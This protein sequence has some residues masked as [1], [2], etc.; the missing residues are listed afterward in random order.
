MAD[1]TTQIGPV[2]LLGPPGAG[3]GTQARNIV[4][5]YGI[6]QISTGDLLR[7]H[8]ARGTALGLE[9]KA[10]MAR[11]ELVPDKLMYGIV[12]DR[13]RAPDCR[14]GFV[15]DGFPRTA[16]QAGWLNAFLGKEL[17]D[18]SGPCAPLVLQL[19]VDY[20]GLLLRLTGRRSCPTC[21]RL[22]NIYLQP[23]RVD[24]LCDVDG[25]PLIF[26]DDDREEVIQGRIS[27]YE[28]QTKP[29]VE[30][31]REQGRLV[32]VNADR[33]LPQVTAEIF[34]VIDDHRKKCE[35]AAMKTGSAPRQ[36][37]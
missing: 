29:L 21:G 23:P 7:D 18:N 2:I 20:G 19:V 28:R 36:S 14:R 31:F 5:R 10:I 37:N 13:L 25:T 11:G 1:E 6:P 15:L 12:A 26:R 8:V 4:E 17:F 27:A 9:A 22:Y 32:P 30:Y 33:E 16:A 34:G 35:L 24:E 3:K